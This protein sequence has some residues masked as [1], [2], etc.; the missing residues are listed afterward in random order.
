MVLLC[1]DGQLWSQLA[2]IRVSG[3]WLLLKRDYRTQTLAN[4]SGRDTF[5]RSPSLLLPLSLSLRMS[6]LSLPLSESAFNLPLSFSLP[7]SLL[8]SRGMI[9]LTGTATGIPSPSCWLGI[10]A[11]TL[12][13]SSERTSV[14]YSV[15]EWSG[16]YSPPTDFIPSERLDCDYVPVLDCD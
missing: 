7:L 3:W 5:Y 10:R 2:R 9:F 12:S 11:S 14:C 15:R 16:I 1:A 6:S 4:D 8:P 13:L